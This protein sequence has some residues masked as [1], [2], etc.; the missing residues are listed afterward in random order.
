MFGWIIFI[1]M[2]MEN[3]IKLVPIGSR[4]YLRSKVHTLD[5]PFGEEFMSQKNFDNFFFFLI[6]M[7]KICQKYFQYKN[8]LAQKKN[9]GP[10]NF[11]VKKILSPKKF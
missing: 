10:I 1:I 3:K 8:F 7:E 2:C 11:Y 4:C 5:F 9:F 6:L